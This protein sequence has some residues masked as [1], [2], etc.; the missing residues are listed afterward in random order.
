MGKNDPALDSDSLHALAEDL[1]V[2]NGKLRRRLREEAHLGDF[3]PSQI[4]VLGLLERDGPA[5]VTELARAHGMRPQSMGETLSVLKAAGLVS[6][7]PDPNDGR[8][9]V[10][11]LTP[12]FRKKI[13]ASRTA[14]E[15]WLFRTI[16]TRFSAAEQRQ[17]ASGVD[18]LKRLIDS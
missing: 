6:G 3:T 9:T 11:S 12:A 10:L 8:Q 5:T 1:R 15:D 4:Q 17:L 16:Q 18:L 14:R 7:A 13:K 2:L